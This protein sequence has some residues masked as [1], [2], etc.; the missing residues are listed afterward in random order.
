MLP[1]F[2]SDIPLQCINESA[3]IY[4][5]PAKL[6]IAVLNV[7]QGKKGLIKKNTNGSYD[8]GEMQINSHWWPMLYQFNITPQDVLYKPCINLRVG[9]WILA[10]EIAEGNNLLEGVGNYNS[11]TPVYNHHYI[12]KV[13]EK[14]TALQFTA[15]PE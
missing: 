14:Y 12:T 7:E 11:H 5:I 2:I 10:R 6:I 9:S 1:L 3:Y 4:R 8:L 15:S 13:R